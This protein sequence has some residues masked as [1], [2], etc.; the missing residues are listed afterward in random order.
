MSYARQSDDRDWLRLISALRGMA[1]DAAFEES[2]HRRDE[3]GKFTSGGGGGGGRGGEAEE[4]PAPHV[5]PAAHSALTKAGFSH[6]P[7]SSGSVEYTRGRAPGRSSAHSIQI[8]PSENQGS[9]WMSFRNSPNYERT[10][11]L[12]GQ[13][14]GHESLLRHVGSKFYGKNAEP[15]DLTASPNPPNPNRPRVGWR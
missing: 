1:V 15:Q 8:H 11:K 13:G 5:H 3:G 2:K 6:K 14:N 4:S 10:D 7:G 12:L 9:R